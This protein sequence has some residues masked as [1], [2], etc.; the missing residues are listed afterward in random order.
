M[1][2]IKNVSKNYNNYSVLKNIS[3]TFPDSGLVII[4]GPSGCGKTTLLNILSGL[5]DFQGDIN[6]LSHHLQQMDEKEKDEF[7][8]KNMGF[9][10]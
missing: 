10:F 4:K 5:L 6:V 3:H 9:I 8:L 2:E 1:I 7:R